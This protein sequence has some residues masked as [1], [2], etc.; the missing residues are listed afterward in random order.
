[1]AFIETVPVDQ[2]TDE[3]RGMYERAQGSLGYVPNWAKVFSQR[4]QVMSGWT[5]LLGSIRGQMDLRRYELVTLA[6]ARALRS[7]YCMLAHG[8]ILRNQF[9]KPEEVT[10]IAGDFSSA[11]LTPAE[12]AMMTFAEQVV[13]DASAIREEDVQGL[14]DHGFSDPEIFDIAAAAAAR[15]FFS[16]LLD[17]L[18][19]EPD[20]AYSQLEGDLQ[21]RLTVGRP[22]SQAPVESVPAAAVPK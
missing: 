16:K 13:R 5:G 19:A 1:M 6:A 3:V 4:P 14:R 18:G 9:Y 15:C 21:S 17:A 8:S 20:A 22:I 7:S 12:V 11:G 10:A 2:A